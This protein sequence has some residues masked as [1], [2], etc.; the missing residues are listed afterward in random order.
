MSTDGGKTW[1]LAALQDPVLPIAQTRFRFP[2]VWDGSPARIMSRAT[3]E[4]GY[5]QPTFRQIAAERGNLE[6]VIYHINHIAAWEIDRDGN[7]KFIHPSQV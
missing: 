1:G 5:A 4:T 2:W 3:D 7:V 6:G